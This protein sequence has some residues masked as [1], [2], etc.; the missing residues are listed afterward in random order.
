M[1]SSVSCSSSISLAL[2]TASWTRIVY[3]SFSPGL[4]WNE[5]YAQEALQTFVRLRC[6]LTLNMTRSPLRSVRTWCARRPSQARSSLPYRATP[7]SRDSRSPAYTFA[8]SSRFRP[9]STP[10]TV[11]P[12]AGRHAGDPDRSTGIQRSV[13]RLGSDRRRHREV[14]QNRGRNGTH[15]DGGMN[16]RS[17]TWIVVALGAMGAL[18]A[19]PAFGDPTPGGVPDRGVPP[20]ATGPLT[21]TGTTPS[22]TQTGTPVVGPMAAQILAQRAQV[23]ALGEQVTKLNLEVEAARQSTEQTRKAWQDAKV[24]ADQLKERA[25]NAAAQAYKDATRLGPWG[26]HANDVSQLDEL[27]P[28]GLANDPADG[29][30]STRSAVLDAAAAAALERSDAAAYDAAVAAQQRL[31]GDK[32]SKTAARAQH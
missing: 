15:R 28:G 22:A 9:G 5:Q 18:I 14:D 8:S 4:R 13:I 2:A 10:S 25:D 29:S 30:G 21:P 27:V 26:D 16:R 1:C 6:R 17:L 19:T 7:S 24:R 12:V 23:E 11:R 3:A 31:E 32:T 20:V